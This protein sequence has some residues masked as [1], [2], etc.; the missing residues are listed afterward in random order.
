M[1]GV[2]LG[3]VGLVV[4]CSPPWT[5]YG[6]AATSGDPQ[7]FA[8]CST[9]APGVATV[10]TDF[11]GF[12]DSDANSNPLL[13]PDGT[14]ILFQVLSSSTGFDEI[15]V[16]DAVAGSTPVQLVADGSNY[17]F[18]PA[19]GP[20]S[21]TFYYVQGSGG[22]TSN[23][24]VYKDTV[25][26]IGSPT[27][28]KA[29][30][31]G[32][33]AMR[34]Q[35]NFDGTRVAYIWTDTPQELRC[36]DSDGSNDGLVDNTISA[37]DSN[38]PP[39]FGWAN[40]QNLIAFQNGVIS[41]QDVFVIDDTG[42]GKVQINANGDAAGGNANVSGYGYAWPAD[43]SFV[44]I[45][46]NIG[47]PVYNIFRAEVDGSDTTQLGTTGPDAGSIP[48][49]RT[50]LIYQSRIWFVS[51]TDGTASKAQVSSMT[52]AGTDERV[53]FDSSLGSGDEVLGFVGGDG[54]YFN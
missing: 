5:A 4:S 7:V 9:N 32:A 12:V 40:T 50:A 21:D 1:G 8:A 20:D 45:V 35:P 33:G 31:G 54:W 19:W 42:G 26:A 6:G 43:D 3:G 38:E 47:N 49:F 48:A 30:A 46:A 14:K 22:A 11:N 15:W 52:L 28:L 39:Q 51:E 16:V 37:Y 2:R 36:M 24:S 18:H 13:S 34:P 23:A 10:F 44:V 27:L 29:A 25:S 41:P 17:C 53:D